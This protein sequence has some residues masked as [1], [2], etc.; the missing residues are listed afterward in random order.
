MESTEK[1]REL[2]TLVS[3][4]PKILRMFLCYKPSPEEEMSDARTETNQGAGNHG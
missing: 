2:D 1:S 3:G 4:M